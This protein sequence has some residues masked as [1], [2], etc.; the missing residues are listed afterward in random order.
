MFKDQ[1][2]VLALGGYGKLIANMTGIVYDKSILLI[3]VG[4][5]SEIPESWNHISPMRLSKLNSIY[6]SYQQITTYLQKGYT[7]EG[8]VISHCHAD[9]IGGTLELFKFLK[10]KGIAKPQV[11]VYAC[12]FT[13]Q[14][15]HEQIFSQ[16]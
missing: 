6:P 1:V 16:V 13:A 8:V 3:D 14:Y 11:P 12:P 7:L 4:R 5:G 15:G 9:H 10:S 2:K